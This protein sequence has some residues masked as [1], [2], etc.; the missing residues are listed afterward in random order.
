M[1]ALAAAAAASREWA[2]PGITLAPPPRGG[3]HSCRR[4]LGGAEAA[5]G[6]R[7]AGRG[8]ELLHPERWF[9]V[10]GRDRSPSWNLRSPLGH[11]LSLAAQSRPK[12]SPVHGSS[13][14]TLSLA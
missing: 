12:P 1:A 10:V 5:A 11:S 6:V 14:Y 3:D 7:G 8:K 4:R 2:G 13:G 9:G